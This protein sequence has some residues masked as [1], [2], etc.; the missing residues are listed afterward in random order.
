MAAAALVL[1]A[2]AAITGLNIDAHAGKDGFHA[3]IDQGSDHSVTVQTKAET[4][5]TPAAAEEAANCPKISGRSHEG[6]DP[7]R[8]KRRLTSGLALAALLVLA[9]NCARRE[10][11]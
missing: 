1:V 8:S 9:C 6:S 4:R 2:L 11:G 3:R 7:R 10:P 5:S